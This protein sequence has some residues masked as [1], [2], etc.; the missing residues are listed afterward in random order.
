MPLFQ[1][2]KLTE[3]IIAALDE[4]NLRGCKSP[5]PPASTVPTPLA[6]IKSMMRL[7]RI[8]GRTFRSLY[9]VDRGSTPQQTNA[10][11]TELDSMLNECESEC[12]GK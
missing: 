11:V 8:M 6:G 9:G 2:A 10:V 5:Q 4:W 1:S 12:D 3:N 7:Q